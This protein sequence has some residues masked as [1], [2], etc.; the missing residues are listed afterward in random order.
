MSTEQAGKSAVVAI[1]AYETAAII[2]GH[3]PTVSALCRRRRWVEAALLAV[4]LAHLH[5]RLEELVESAVPAAR[6]PRRHLPDLTAHRPPLGQ[7]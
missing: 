5:M 6:R 4:L 7:P 2:T 3:V 1:C